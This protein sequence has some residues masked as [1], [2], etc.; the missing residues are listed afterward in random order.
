LI[1]LLRIVQTM[2]ACLSEHF[3][4]LSVSGRTCSDSPAAPQKSAR[5]SSTCPTLFISFPSCCFT[6]SFDFFSWNLFFL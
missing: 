5:S 4:S 6:V 1:H 3:C 2:N